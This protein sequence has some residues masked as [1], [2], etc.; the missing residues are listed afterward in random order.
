MIDIEKREYI[1][2]AYRYRAGYSDIPP[3]TRV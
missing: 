2:E 1:Y 3:E